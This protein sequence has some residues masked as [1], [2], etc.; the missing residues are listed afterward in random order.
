MSSAGADELAVALSVSGDFRVP[1][2]NPA[3][4][5][6]LD[7]YYYDFLTEAGVDVSAA[8]LSKREHG[9]VF[10]YEIF[11]LVDGQRTVSEIRDILAGRYFP[12]PLT[13]ISEYMDL[14]AKAKAITWK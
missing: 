3:I 12:A 8:K 13:E 11:N 5:G 2:R 10:A 14:L 7:V 1:V 9:E 4:Q 6:P